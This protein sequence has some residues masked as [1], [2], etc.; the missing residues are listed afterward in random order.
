M[1]EKSIECEARGWTEP[2]SLWSRIL[3]MV[4]DDLSGRQSR[5]FFVEIVGEFGPCRKEI[6]DLSTE[7]RHSLHPA[8]RERV[9]ERLLDRY[10][11]ERS[12]VDLADKRHA[13][14][15]RLEDLT[16]E[17]LPNL[18]TADRWRFEEEDNERERAEFVREA[19]EDLERLLFEEGRYAEAAEAHRKLIAHDAY[20]EEAH[21]GLMRCQA[22]LGEPGQAIR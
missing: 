14:T 17:D 20:L 5:K 9:A 6:G 22:A 13:Y 3:A 7:E 19:T 16:P 4:E 2:S 10:L 18:I 8:M 12:R 21:R 1:Y 15:K 11:A